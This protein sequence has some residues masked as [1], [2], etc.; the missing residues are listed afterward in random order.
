MG[1][2]DRHLLERR[3]ISFG[4]LVLPQRWGLTVGSVRHSGCGLDEDGALLRE[5]K[6]ELSTLEHR[7]QRLRR[8]EP[9][10]NRMDGDPS[11]LIEQEEHVES[12]L[13]SKPREHF[14]CVATRQ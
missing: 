10:L 1:A 6:S 2:R 8:L 14:R 9:T 13:D 12:R 3:V 4:G 11:N 7:G 5:T